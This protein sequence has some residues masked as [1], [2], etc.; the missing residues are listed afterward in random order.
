MN[1]SAKIRELIGTGSV[2]GVAHSKRLINSCRTGSAKKAWDGFVE[3][4]YVQTCLRNGVSPDFIWRYIDGNNHFEG[5]WSLARIHKVRVRMNITANVSTATPEAGSYEISSDRGWGVEIELISD[6]SKREVAAKLN[7][8]RISTQVDDRGERCYRQGDWKICDDASL[9]DGGMEIVSPIL[10]GTK[11]L[12]ELEKVCTVLKSCRARI[13]SSC[14][15]HIHHQVTTTG[16][17]DLKILQNAMYVYHKFQS[18]INRMLPKSRRFADP[19]HP[20][21]SGDIVRALEARD[22]YNLT[23][24]QDRRQAVNVQAYSR[25]GTCEFRQHSGSIESEKIGYWVIITQSIMAKAIE[26][27]RNSSDIT[28]YEFKRDLVEEM[29]LKTEVKTYIEKRM[30]KF[31][32]KVA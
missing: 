13:D 9:S 7:S 25:H 14:G 8:H 15:L 12:E 22:V 11:G 27:A 5:R 20:H 2:E 30:E 29:K 17:D 4:H 10:K 24:S 16:V 31:N 28:A 6:L 18:R 26:L 32:K 1:I 19:C 21:S 23:A 3:L